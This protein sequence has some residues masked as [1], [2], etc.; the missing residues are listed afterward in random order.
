MEYDINSLY[1]DLVGENIKYLINDYNNEHNKIFNDF[2]L[3]RG[4]I[5]NE[6][7][8][9]IFRHLGDIIYPV[10]DLLFYSRT[11]KN[12]NIDDVINTKQFFNANYIGYKIRKIGE[13]KEELK[14]INSSNISIS[15]CN[16]VSLFFINKT[17]K[18]INSLFEYAELL[19]IKDINK[20]FYYY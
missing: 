10:N 11:F 20:L 18:F 16:L 8:Y 6:D 9:Y 13:I 5:I 7:E 4:N 3:V 17:Y 1:P 19:N 15:F 2:L 14:K 12:E